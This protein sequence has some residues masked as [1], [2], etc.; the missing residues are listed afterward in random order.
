MMGVICNAVILAV[1]LLHYTCAFKVFP[2]HTSGSTI[3]TSI[4]QSQR[5]KIAYNSP[6]LSLHSATET[7]F[8]YLPE[9]HSRKQEFE[10]EIKDI[11][12]NSVFSLGRKYYESIDFH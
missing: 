10:R 11:A 9:S 2:I 6:T 3:L 5:L 8:G 4:G 7:N 12:K 1:F